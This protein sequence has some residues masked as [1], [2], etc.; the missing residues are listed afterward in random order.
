MQYTASTLITA[1]RLDL[2]T[3][4]NIDKSCYYLSFLDILASIRLQLL[5]Q[6]ETKF[7]LVNVSYTLLK[8]PMIWTFFIELFDLNTKL[9]MNI[10]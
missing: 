5:F 8:N 10:L 9:Y 6:M 4:V 7:R 3:T 1:C 2:L